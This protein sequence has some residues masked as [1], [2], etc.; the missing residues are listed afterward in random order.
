M[1]FLESFFFGGSGGDGGRVISIFNRSTGVT[2]RDFFF[3]V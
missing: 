2:P 3:S 1:E